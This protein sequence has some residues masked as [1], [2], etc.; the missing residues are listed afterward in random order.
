VLEKEAVSAN[1]VG[2]PTAKVDSHPIEKISHR[3]SSY[4]NG[5]VGFNHARCWSDERKCK[6]HEGNIKQRRLTGGGKSGSARPEAEARS[7][8]PCMELVQSELGHLG[9]CLPYQFG[10]NNVADYWQI[11]TLVIC[12]C[13]IWNRAQL[14]DSLRM[15][16]L[17][18]IPALKFVR[19][20]QKSAETGVT[21]TRSKT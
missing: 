1:Q 17:N 6:I 21:C 7:S 8:T 2:G 12:L 18:N 16:G 3:S 10:E 19:L 13:Q 5:C 15:D 11:M 9:C 20:C 4:N 14:I